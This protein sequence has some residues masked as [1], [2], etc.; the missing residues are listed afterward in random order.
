MAMM[1]M[2]GSRELSWLQK[3]L[4]QVNDHGTETDLLVWSPKQITTYV[5]GGVCKVLSDL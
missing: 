1:H 5:L 4:N 3:Q 2:V